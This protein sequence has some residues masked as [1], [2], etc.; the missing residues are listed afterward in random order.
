MG[1]PQGS[2]LPKH[3][4]T[5]LA[6]LTLLPAH[7]ICRVLRGK[8]IFNLDCHLYITIK[9]IIYI[10]V[11]FARQRRKKKTHRHTT[12]YAC[13]WSIIKKLALRFL[14]KEDA[15]KALVLDRTLPA[16]QLRQS[17][18]PE[19]H[20][21]DAAGWPLPVHRSWNISLEEYCKIGHFSAWVKSFFSQN[22]H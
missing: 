21:T 6:P 12:L 11:L 14:S 18:S 3:T 5:C 17:G 20:S 4:C 13:N 2:I 15:Q 8:T 7:P 19:S 16:K 22:L 10:H 1:F 9:C